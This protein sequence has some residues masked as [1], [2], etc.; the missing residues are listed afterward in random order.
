[1]PF[2]SNFFGEQIAQPGTTQSEIEDMIFERFGSNTVT[3]HNADLFTTGDENLQFGG[4][5]YITGTM[6]DDDGDDDQSEDIQIEFDGFASLDEARLWL[7]DALY[8]DGTNIN[9]VD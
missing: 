2:R 6:S 5:L 3:F 9:E 4:T 1:M 7:I 8:F